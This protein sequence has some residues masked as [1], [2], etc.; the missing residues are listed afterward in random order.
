MPTVQG[1]KQGEGIQHYN[2]NEAQ[3][4]SG[5][6]SVWPA[7][8]STQGLLDMSTGEKLILG[9]RLELARMFRGHNDHWGIQDLIVLKAAE[10]TK[11]VKF[12][13]LLL[14]HMLALKNVITNGGR[15]ILSY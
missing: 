1:K 2:T 5:Q 15:S 7:C 13:E 3:A 10:S 6:R 11:G 14:N 4:V 8:V 9:L 12:V